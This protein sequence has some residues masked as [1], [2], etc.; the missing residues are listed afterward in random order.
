MNGCAR[1]IQHHLGTG[2]TGLQS[3]GLCPRIQALKMA[4]TA[5]GDESEG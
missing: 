3:Q 5:G 4:A 1:G 2:V